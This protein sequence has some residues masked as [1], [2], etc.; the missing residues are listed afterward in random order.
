ML[1]ANVATP[2]SKKQIKTIIIPIDFAA[3]GAL[4]KWK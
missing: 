1:L 4:E 3:G 2:N